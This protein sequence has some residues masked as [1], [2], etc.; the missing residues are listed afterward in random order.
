MKDSDLKIEIVGEQDVIPTMSARECTQTLTPQSQGYFRRTVSGELKCINA[1]DL[2][3]RST[4]H[5]QDKIPPA[6]SKLKAG[7]VVRVHCIQYLT[8]SV[9]KDSV[10]HQLEREG[11]DINLFDFQGKRWTSK[12][13]QNRSVSITQGFQGGFIMY[14]PILTMMVK[15]FSFETNEWNLSVSWTLELEEC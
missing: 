9:A 8:E 3:Y 14:K 15:S 7:S 1:G 11:F 2:K 13:L 10:S 12:P 4:I 6:L 5:C